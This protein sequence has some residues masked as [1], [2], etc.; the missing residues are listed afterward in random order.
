M[1]GEAPARR[2]ARAAFAAAS[3]EPQPDQ[4]RRCTC[5]RSLRSR[6][7]VPRRCAVRVTPPRIKLG[8]SITLDLS[9]QPSGKKAQ[10]LVIDYAIHH[11]KASGGTSPKVFK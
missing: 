2:V 10:A 8:E 5:A 1:A 6:R 9:L 11:V 4:G 7:Q 3:C